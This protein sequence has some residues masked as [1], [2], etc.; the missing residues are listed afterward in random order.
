MKRF[1]LAILAIICS[2]AAPLVALR[3]EVARVPRFPLGLPERNIPRWEQLD[4]ACLGTRWQDIKPAMQSFVDYGTILGA[5]TLVD[6]RG[7]PLQTDAV[8]AFAPDTIFQVMSMAKPIVSVLVLKLIEDGKIPSSETRV[9]T[10]PGF[11]DFP[12]RD[13]TIKRL[14]THTS[15]IWYRRDLAPG[16][17]AGVAP[18]LTNKFDKEPETSTRDKTLDFVARHYANATL[19]PLGSTDYHYSNMGFMMLGWIV[20]R[21]HGKPFEVVA[22]E[23]IFEPLGLTDTFYFPQS[24]TPGQRKRIADLDRRLSDPP[25]YDHYKKTRPGWRYVSPEGGLHSTARDLRQFMGLLRH[26]GQLPGGS[27]VLKSESV[28]RLLR[29]EAPDKNAGYNAGVGRSLGFYVAREPAPAELPGFDPGTVSHGG[30]FATEF[31]YNPKKDEIGIFLC[32]MVQRTPEPTP[33]DGVA[34][35]FK[36]ILARIK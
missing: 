10:L 11:A 16:V 22:K 21:L 36:Q 9:V 4:P 7:S 15:G 31:W 34:D 23:Q 32:Q 13:V 5:V 29:D 33:T 12:Y 27:R 1:Q 14:L 35:A 3:G 2:V 20:E 8:G 6:R 24:A 28:E 30:R 25:D 26:R 17:R 18:H 19:Y